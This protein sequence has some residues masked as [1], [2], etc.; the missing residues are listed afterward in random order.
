MLCARAGVG[1][2]INLS[3][4]G[5]FVQLGTELAAAV[6][7]ET[8]DC[9]AQCGSGTDPA[10]GRDMLRCCELTGEVGAGS[11]STGGVLKIKEFD[12]LERAVGTGD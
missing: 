1:S 11:V 8:L 5:A 2:F 6:N 10:S 12:G 7:D 9:N 4:A 3:G